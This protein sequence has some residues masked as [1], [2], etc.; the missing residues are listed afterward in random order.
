MPAGAVAPGPGT[1]PDAWG[2]FALPVLHSDRLV[3]KVDATADR[4]HGRL[5]VHAIHEDVPFTPEVTRA[6]H[7]ELHDLASWLSLTAE[8]LR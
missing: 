2:Y 3:G 7:E 8:G 1:G 6:V 4:R 5:T